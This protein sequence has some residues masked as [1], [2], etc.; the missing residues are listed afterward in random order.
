MSVS[1]HMSVITQYGDSALMMAV[2]SWG[3]CFGIEVVPLLLEAEA[4]IHL[5][6]EVQNFGNTVC[7]RKCIFC[8]LG[9]A[10]SRYCTIVGLNIYYSLYVYLLMLMDAIFQHTIHVK[11]FPIVQPVLF[12]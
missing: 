3:Y 10:C 12:R 1:L 7:T 9:R 2:K 6:N 11:K 4:K 8:V 5:Q